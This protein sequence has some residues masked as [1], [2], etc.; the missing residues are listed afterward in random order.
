MIKQSPDF[1]T[2]GHGFESQ[3]WRDFLRQEIIDPQCAAF[4]T[5]EVNG[6]LAGINSL[7]RSACNSCSAKAMVIMLHITV[8]HLETS[9]KVSV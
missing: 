4:N 8:E 3:P 5:G 2:E 9:D 7:K 1:E 6:Y